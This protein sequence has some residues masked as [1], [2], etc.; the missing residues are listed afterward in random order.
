LDSNDSGQ[1]DINNPKSWNKDS[2][3]HIESTLHVNE[4]SYDGF[5]ALFSVRNDSTDRDIDY[6]EVAW[7][8]EKVLVYHCINVHPLRLL[9]QES[10]MARQGLE[11]I[12]R[13]VRTPGR[14]RAGYVV[15]LAYQLVESITYSQV[16]LDTVFYAVDIEMKKKQLLHQLGDLKM[17]P[18][19]DDRIR[20]QIKDVREFM[21][22]DQVDLLHKIKELKDQQKLGIILQFV[23]LIQAGDSQKSMA[24][25]NQF[26]SFLSEKEDNRKTSIKGRNLSRS[27]SVRSRKQ[28][29]S[30]FSSCSTSSELQAA[31]G[32]T[33]L[34]KRS[35]SSSCASLSSP[36]RMTRPGT[37]TRKS[38]A[39]DK[40]Q[41]E[42]ADIQ[43]DRENDESEISDAETEK[44]GVSVRDS[45]AASTST[46]TVVKRRVTSAGSNANGRQSVRKI[47]PMSASD[48]STSEDRRVRN[49][50]T[51]SRIVK[52]SSRTGSFT[53][54][55]SSPRPS[56]RKSMK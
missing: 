8:L 32:S 56:Q 2:I 33:V 10:V 31:S 43:S 20:K 4:I 12:S 9:N 51:V 55:S 44:A 27:N 25:I 30:S 38:S 40:H 14:N 36:R 47:R 49:S 48:I 18:A 13:K 21:G 28:S 37:S 34:V 15:F 26:V 52:D 6:D 46:E 35:M 54:S 5:V 23:Q 19:V 11:P 3:T 7:E 41:S 17:S 42:L 1:F 22:K 53:S 39:R 45:A 24:G 29:S 16:M 50:V